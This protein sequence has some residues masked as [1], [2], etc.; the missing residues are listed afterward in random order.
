MERLSSVLELL[1]LVAVVA[2]AFLFA[3][4]LGVLVTGLVLV[5][6]GLALGRGSA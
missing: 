4:W 3:L 6:V 2:G 1:G 5:L